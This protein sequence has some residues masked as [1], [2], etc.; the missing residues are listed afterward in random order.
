MNIEE[1]KILAEK[2]VNGSS[3]PEEK[4]VFLTEL[5]ET[6]DSIRRDLSKLKNK[7]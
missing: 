3:S 6:L 7:K 5:N 1:I 4:L 2:V